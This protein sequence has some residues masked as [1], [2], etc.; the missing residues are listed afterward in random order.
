MLPHSYRPGTDLLSKEML[1]NPFVINIVTRALLN[2]EGNYVTD[3]PEWPNV[4][5]SDVVLVHKEATT[6]HPPI[7]IE[8]QRTVGEDFVK[9]VLI[10]S[11]QLEKR[12]KTVTICPV[13]R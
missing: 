2:S 12:H 9:K 13:T 6:D 3:S 7:I 5:R 1:R 11:N 4:M 10:H 8:F